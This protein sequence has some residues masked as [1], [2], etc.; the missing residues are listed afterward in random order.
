MNAEAVTKD[1]VLLLRSEIDDLEKAG[2]YLDASLLRCSGLVGRSDLSLEEMER[3][4]ALTSRFARVADMLIQR[5]M[6]LVDE[7]ELVS[8]GSLLD[9]IYRA[10]KRGWVDRGEQ[11]VHVRELRNLIAHEYGA[12]KMLEIHASVATMAP[13]LLMMLPK[14]KAYVDQLVRHF[15]R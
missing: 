5:V 14:V 13:G 6:R 15:D 9:R 12:D 7:L 1:K 4:E 10:E 11:L 3:L 2:A 8:Q